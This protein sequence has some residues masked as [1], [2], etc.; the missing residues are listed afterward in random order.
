MGDAIA[1]ERV[2]EHA[3]QRVL[4]DELIKVLRAV[5]AREHDARRL[6]RAGR[7]IISRSIL[8]A[9]AH[10][11]SR[12]ATAA[13]CAANPTKNAARRNT[14]SRVFGVRGQRPEL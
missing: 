7:S 5:F 10:R 2:G 3:D 14:P 8:V 12:P 4:P 13:A 6:K 9:F 1:L 11:R